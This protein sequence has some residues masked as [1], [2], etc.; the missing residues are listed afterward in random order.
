MKTGEARYSGAMPIR[1]ATA[2][3]PYLFTDERVEETALLR[4][5][6]RLPRGATVIFRH[7]QT[8][9][10]ARMALYRRLRTITRWRGV[11]LFVRGEHP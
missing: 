10:P 1:Q 11:M 3:T 6:R 5:V 2:P 8:P 9:E 4:A 7:Y